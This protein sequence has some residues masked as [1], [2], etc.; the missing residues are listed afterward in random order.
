MGWALPRR[1]TSSGAGAPVCSGICYGCRLFDEDEIS[2]GADCSQERTA[3]ATG[4]GNQRG[5]I[6]IPIRPALYNE[7]LRPLENY[8]QVGWFRT[9]CSYTGEFVHTVVSAIHP[10]VVS[11]NALAFVRAQQPNHLS[12][13]FAYS[14]AAA[15][16]KLPHQVARS[17]MVSNADV[18]EGEG[19]NLI[20]GKSNEDV[21]S[22]VPVEDMPHIIHYCKYAAKSNLPIRFLAYPCL[23]KIRQKL[24]LPFSRLF[25]GCQ[26]KTMVSESISF[27]NIDFP[28]I[29]SPASLLCSRSLRVTLPLCSITWSARSTTTNVETST[30]Q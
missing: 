24:M 1:Q 17:F 2:D 19:W 30:T 10:I 22:N 21:C 3:F 6:R 25:F 15:H 4:T 20:E 23:T 7:G 29:S 18:W 8:Q 27:P 12:E 9:S 16:L 5:C 14:A 11:D 28:G 13:M 26:V